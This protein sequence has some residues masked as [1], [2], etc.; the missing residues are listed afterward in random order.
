MER[1]T[2]PNYSHMVDLTTQN[3]IISPGRPTLVIII[4]PIILGFL[5]DPP[6]PWQ[7]I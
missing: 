3:A 6:P 5:L 7:F 2:P 4:V 1:K